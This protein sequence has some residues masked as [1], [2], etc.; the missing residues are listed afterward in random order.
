MAKP[1]CTQELIDKAAELKRH[2]LANKD[3]CQAL[4]ISETTFYRWLQKPTNRLHRAL[5]ESL[6]KAE[7]DYKGEL[8]K[9]IEET[10]T[11]A[12]NPQWTV[13]YNFLRTLTAE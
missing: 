1:K 11:R 5:S 12:K 9:S 13:T 6:K 8:L 7:A 3:I 4:C 10:A 2:G